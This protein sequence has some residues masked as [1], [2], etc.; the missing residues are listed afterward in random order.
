[1]KYTGKMPEPLGSSQRPQ[2][3]PANSQRPNSLRQ[4]GFGGRSPLPS[5]SRFIQQQGGVE[6]LFQGAAKSAK[7]VLERGE[8][9]GINQAVREAMTEIRRNMQSFNESRPSPRTTRSIMLSEDGAAKALVAM[10]RRNKQ[11]A[12]LLDETVTNLKTVFM[13]NL[14]DR[15]KSLELIEIAAAKIQFVQVYLGDS[16]MEVPSFNAPAAEEAAVEGTTKAPDEKPGEE[17]S[18]V[19][20]EAPA[21]EP[22]PRNTAAADVPKLSLTDD[23]PPPPK[24]DE[25]VTSPNPT[26]KATE[27]D[28][29]KEDPLS[30]A[31][32]ILRPSAPIPTRSTLAQS[33]FSWM[34]E[35]DESATART[36]P[37][38]S[39]PP[40]TQH[41]KRL[42]N[43]ASR[44]RNAFLFG[45]A[46]AEATRKADEIFGMEPIQK[47]KNKS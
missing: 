22:A 23:K 39:K 29:T 33:S 10:E 1:M 26:Q 43:N 36:P 8:K 18:E 20:V 12:S 44:E 41:K 7:G 31:P 13:G 14:D 40:T 11:L 4:R 21:V 15:A 25:A 2:L 46:M 38:A 32:A 47:S 5:P 19:E 34:L 30:N 45:E 24:K 17:D 42:S 28:D 6:S 9:L 16:S 37:S 35:P 3:S 27:R